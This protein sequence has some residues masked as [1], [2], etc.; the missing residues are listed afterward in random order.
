[1]SMAVRASS[2]EMRTGADE[3]AGRTERQAGSI[4]ETANAISAITQSVRRQIERAEQAER[5]ARDAKK[6]TTGS[7]QIMRET[8]AAMEAIQTS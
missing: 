7:G 8:I 1:N 4:T 2:E 3:L 6:E 5:I